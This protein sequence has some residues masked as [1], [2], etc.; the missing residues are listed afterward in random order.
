LGGV[1]EMKKLLLIALLVVGCEETVA[2]DTTAPTI[3]ITYPAN[4]STLTETTTV[5]VDVADDGE[6]GIVKLL[7][8]GVETY[9]DTTAPYQFVWDVCVQSTGT[10]TLMAKTEDG[11][12]NQGQSDLLTFTI[13][14]NYDCADVCGGDKLL[15]NCEVCDADTSNDC[16]ADCNGDWGGSSYKDECDDCVGGNTVLTACLQDDCGI[17][18]GANSPNTGTCDCE[19]TP[20]GT[21]WVSDCGCVSATNSGDDCDDCE[22][23]PNG[24]MIADS[25]GGCCSSIPTDFCDCNSENF[26]LWYQCYNI[27]GTIW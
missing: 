7:V 19:G 21:A 26:S 14:A 11:A 4:S 24:N 27:E 20:N 9:A 13:N 6:I 23:T 12:G 8:D 17:W 18:G 3:V 16:T 25:Y 10:H 15:D 5:T 1:G 22:G 2:P